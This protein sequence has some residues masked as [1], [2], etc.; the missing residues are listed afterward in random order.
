MVLQNNFLGRLNSPE[1]VPIVIIKLQIVKDVR[2]GEVE[3]NRDEEQTGKES[4]G[5]CC[6][7][8]PF[9]PCSGSS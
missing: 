5:Q 2:R 8:V 7:A 1:I 4:L 3:E 9:W 6:V